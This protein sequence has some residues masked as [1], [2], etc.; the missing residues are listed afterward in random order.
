MVSLP[1]CVR[2]RPAGYSGDDCAIGIFSTFAFV[3]LITGFI[4]CAV[5]D[6]D[7]CASLPCDNGGTCLD[8]MNSYYCACVVEY[9][10]E[11][12]EA[13]VASSACL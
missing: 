10:G 1:L 5:P 11:N 8:G 9:Y 2:A 6:I 4:V 13:G 3:Q 12:C 7:E